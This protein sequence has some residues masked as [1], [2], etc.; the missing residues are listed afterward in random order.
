MINIQPNQITEDV[1]AIIDMSNEET[2]L[3]NLPSLDESMQLTL[4]NSNGDAE[5]DRLVITSAGSDFGDID[6]NNGNGGR[7]ENKDRTPKKKQP[8]K[9]E[10]KRQQQQQ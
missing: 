2:S 7:R 9:K 6:G 3:Q 5:L 4:N 10:E 8:K 1:R